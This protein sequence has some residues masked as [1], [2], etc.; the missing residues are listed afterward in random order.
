MY[1]RNALGDLLR[2]A[3]TGAGVTL[4]ELQVLT[5]VSRELLRRYESGA[6]VPGNDRLVH[7]LSRLG[8]PGTT[9]L[10]QQIIAAAKATRCEGLPDAAEGEV[11]TRVV[12]TYFEMSG[13]RRS[14]E[15]EFVVRAAFQ[16]A[17]RG[18]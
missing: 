9:P 14:A 12:D 10:G 1:N 7:I 2:Q 13:H 11:L 6:A 17:I 5:G 18:K 15:S 4:L 3:R 16:A 8:V